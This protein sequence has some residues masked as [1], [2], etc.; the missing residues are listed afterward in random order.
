MKTREVGF[1]DGTLTGD[2]ENRISN[3]SPPIDPPI[4]D[5]FSSKF[6]PSLKEQQLYNAYI[7]HEFLSE[8]FDRSLEGV[9][10]QFG[11]YI[12]SNLRVSTKNSEAIRNRVCK[13][14]DIKAGD[15]IKFS[16]KQSP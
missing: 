15:L 7:E 9:F 10:N 16:M 2:E 14:Y 3:W 12:P 5:V 11:D 1:S 6:I 8:Q 4:L 13:E